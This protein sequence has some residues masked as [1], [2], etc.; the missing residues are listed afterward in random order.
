M[1]GA[2]SPANPAT[3][4]PIALQSPPTGRQQPQ[5]PWKRSRT[6]GTEASG[7]SAHAGSGD[8]SGHR[9][10]RTAG[11]GNLN[12]QPGQ[13]RRSAN[14]VLQHTQRHLPDVA[15]LRPAQRSSVTPIPPGLTRPPLATAQSRPA[16]LTPHCSCRQGR[17][18]RLSS[19]HHA[20][21]RWPHSVILLLW[22]LS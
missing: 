4:V 15:R 21:P 6:G 18:H 22:S 20:C 2:D 16:G 9:L 13:R 3:F 8:H 7:Q 11:T 10:R 14:R 12:S 19:Q 1:P 5:R 17:L